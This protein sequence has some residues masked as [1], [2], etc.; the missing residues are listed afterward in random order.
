MELVTTEKLYDT[1]PIYLLYTNVSYSVCHFVT[2]TFVN[3]FRAKV[4][5]YSI[6]LQPCP[7]VLDEGRSNWQWRSHYLTT[8]RDY[9]LAQKSFMIMANDRLDSSL[10]L[11]LHYLKVFWPQA[12]DSSKFKQM[13]KKLVNPSGI[14]S[15][16]FIGPNTVVE[17][18]PHLQLNRN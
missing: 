8:L 3:F 6:K 4:W 18:L 17:C 16:S 1:C 14:I 9:S 5:T 7:Q 10:D 11:S 13:L 2:Y 12:A 15:C